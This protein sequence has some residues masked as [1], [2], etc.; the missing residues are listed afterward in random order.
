MPPESAMVSI[1]FELKAPRSTTTGETL[2]GTLVVFVL[3]APPAKAANAGVMERPRLVPAMTIPVARTAI[4]ANC[5]AIPKG[6]ALSAMVRMRS[7]PKV[8]KVPGSVAPLL[9]TAVTVV[10]ASVAHD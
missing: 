9:V 7:A 5:C 2:L 1:P 10:P 4:V 6:V 8:A 3:K